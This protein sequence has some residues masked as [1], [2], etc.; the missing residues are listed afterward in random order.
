VNRLVN[1]GSGRTSYENRVS[2]DQFHN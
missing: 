1:P 2:T